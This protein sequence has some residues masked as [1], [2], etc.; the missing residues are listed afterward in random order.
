MNRTLLF[1]MMRPLWGI[2]A[3]FAVIG[4]LLVLFIRTPLFEL[5]MSPVL[6]ATGLTLSTI[7]FLSAIVARKSGHLYTRGFSRDTIWNH[8]MAATALTILIA[9]TPPAL[10]VIAPI[11]SLFQDLSMRN[12]YYPLVY[13]REMLVPIEWL[14]C[15]ITFACV[16]HYLWIRRLQ[17]CVNYGGGW[18][19][20]AGFAVTALTL[21]N[22]PPISHQPAML[23]R[24]LFIGG[25]IFI[26]AFTLI[27]S[28]KLHRNLE[29]LA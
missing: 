9:W 7:P 11:R 19:L 4:S 26:S 21:F 22:L 2:G 18:L 13:P 20:G 25:A 14:G 27:A 5:R 28:R 29:L 8:C 1:W 16:G 12:G 6:W 15:A 23:I 3:I 17:P 10:I 24:I